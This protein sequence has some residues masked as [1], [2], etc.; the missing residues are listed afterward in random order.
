MN[1]LLGFTAAIVATA[2]ITIS[3]LL[4]SPW[5]VATSTIGGTRVPMLSCEEDEVIA[6]IG[7]D[8]LGCVHRDFIR[9]E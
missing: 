1:L 4:I 7:I 3:L 9:A 8:T 5:N 6:F 2:I